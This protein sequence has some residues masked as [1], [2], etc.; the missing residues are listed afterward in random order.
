MQRKLRLERSAEPLFR[1]LVR[2]QRLR[3]TPLYPV[4][5]TEVRRVERAL[6]DE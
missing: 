4:G 5:R 2:A 6:V 3:G 1:T